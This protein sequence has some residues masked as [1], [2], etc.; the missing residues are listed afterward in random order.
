MVVAGQGQNESRLREGVCKTCAACTLRPC[1][2][3]QHACC[4]SLASPTQTSRPKL[5]DAQRDQLREVFMLM[6]SSGNGAIDV[7]ELGDALALMGGR[8]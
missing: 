6:D 5:T 8:C 3:W 7:N 1:S 2:A 4:W